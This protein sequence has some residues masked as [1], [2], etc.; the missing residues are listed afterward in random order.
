M[1]IK[2]SEFYSSHWRSCHEPRGG[3]DTSKHKDH[4][5]LLSAKYVAGTAASQTHCLIDEPIRGA[6]SLQLRAHDEAQCPTG[7]ASP[8]HRVEMYTAAARARSEWH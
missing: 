7:R 5:L 4:A 2:K 1:P 8:S 3:M 6:D